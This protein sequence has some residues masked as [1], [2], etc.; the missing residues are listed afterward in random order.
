ME[1]VQ[2]HPTAIYVFAK[3]K[4]FGGSKMKNKFY[5]EKFNNNFFS[6]SREEQYQLLL[7]GVCPPAPTGFYHREKVTLLGVSNDSRIPLMEDLPR[8]VNL[9]RKG[10]TFDFLDKF[11]VNYRLGGISTT[12]DWFDYIGYKNLRLFYFYYIFEDKYRDNPA[13]A[14]EEVVEYEVKTMRILR[15]SLSF[16]IGN[17]FLAPIKKLKGLFNGKNQI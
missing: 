7:N 16:K 5:E 1:Y 17:L 13:K 14:I 12:K 11:V 4:V 9:Y 15:E 6:T 10:V 8:W 3:I 2:N